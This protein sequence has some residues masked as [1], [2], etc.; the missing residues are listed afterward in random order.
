[1]KYRFAMLQVLFLVAAMMI[2]AAMPLGA[3][4]PSGPTIV[5]VDGDRATSETGV[6]QQ[7]R[8]RVN[9]AA[10]QWQSRINSLQTELTNLGQ[11]RQT[12]QLTLSQEALSSLNAQIE[13]KQVELQRVQDD[14]RRAIERLQ[15]QSVEQI[16][17][18][19]IPVLEALAAERGYEIVLDTR[20]TQTGGLLYY[21]NVLDVTD[22]FIA[23]VNA[24]EG[25]AAQQ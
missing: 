23:R 4:S 20:M 24:A 15:V 1:M 12:Q 14:A 11:Q 5:L 9:A 25:N 17:G 13:E 19:L 16:N 22:D 8:D 2:G 3:Q 21:S 7:V 6:G 18:V 10:E